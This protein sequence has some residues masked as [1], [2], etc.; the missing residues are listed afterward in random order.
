MYIHQQVRSKNMQH[1]I[2]AKQHLN[3][4]FINYKLGQWPY[5]TNKQYIIIHVW[6]VSAAQ[7]S[8]QCARYA[9]NKVLCEFV[10]SCKQTLNEHKLT[11]FN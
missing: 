3:L 8:Y 7:T 9:N 11:P 5:A 4:F 2:H 10:F 6:Q 1:T